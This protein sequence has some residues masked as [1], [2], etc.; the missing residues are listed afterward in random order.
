M[1][2]DNDQGTVK[3]LLLRTHVTIIAAAVA[4]DVVVVLDKSSIASNTSSSGS[5]NRSFP[6][7]ICVALHYVLVVVLDGSGK[8][9]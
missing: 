7:S 3:I 8:K 6:T 2:L 9:L 5:T 1:Q 4:V